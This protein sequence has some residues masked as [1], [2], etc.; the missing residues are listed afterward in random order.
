M[1]SYVLWLKFNRYTGNFERE[2]MAYMLGYTNESQ[3]GD[4]DVYE[5]DFYKSGQLLS[6]KNKLKFSCQE[7]DDWS[8]RTCYNI[9]HYPFDDKNDRLVK[10]V[11]NENGIPMPVPREKNEDEYD[12]CNS[13]YIEF[14]HAPTEKE[15]EEFM[16]RA[17]GFDTFLKLN[18]KYCKEDVKITK[19]K[20]CQQQIT[21]IALR[22]DEEYGR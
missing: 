14:S 15:I 12:G 18:D 11:F 4:F 13:I 21:Y 6:L 19:Y 17:S 9:G 2:F 5:N 3:K 10:V 20:L 1:K 16:L 7:V 8:E 22:E